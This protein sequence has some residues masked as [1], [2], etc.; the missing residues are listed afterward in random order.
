MM[1][2]LVKKCRV[3]RNSIDCLAGNVLLAPEERVTYTP[4]QLVS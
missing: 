3:N 4:W 1:G 2:R